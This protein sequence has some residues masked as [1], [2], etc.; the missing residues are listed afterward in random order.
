M[1]CLNMICLFVSNISLVNIIANRCVCIVTGNCIELIQVDHSKYTPCSL[2]LKNL[3][4]LYDADTMSLFFL[5]L[6]SSF[7]D[8]VHFLFVVSI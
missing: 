5:L 4:I 1:Y 2:S 8:A 7:F 3:Y 6:L